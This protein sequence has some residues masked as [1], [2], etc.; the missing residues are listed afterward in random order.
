MAGPK[1]RPI[2]DAEEEALQAGA[3]RKGEEPIGTGRFL[4]HETVREWLKDLAAGHYRPPPIPKTW[5]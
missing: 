1:R 4:P 3:V 5:K 2:H